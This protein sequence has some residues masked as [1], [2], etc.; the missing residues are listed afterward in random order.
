MDELAGHHPALIQRAEAFAGDRAYDETKLIEKLWSWQ[1]APIIP[2]REDWRGEPTRPLLA[3]ADNVTYDCQGRIRCYPPGRSQAW[4]MVYASYDRERDA[5]KWRC[6][7]AYYGMKCRGQGRCCSASDYGRVVW[8]KRQWDRRTFTPVA[9]A[10][11]KFERLY[12]K[13]SAVERVNS[14]MGGGYGL[15]HHFIRGQAKM[16]LRCALSLVTML[17]LAAGRL[18]ENKEAALGGGGRAPTV[19]SLVGAA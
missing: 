13:R 4:Q 10:S 8:V 3:G 5:Q 6:P 9:R 2:K 15:D 18:Q 14:R 17:S 7:A 11:L 19:R 12:K 16:R 1:V